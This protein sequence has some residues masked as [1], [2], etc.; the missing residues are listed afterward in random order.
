MRS[1]VYSLFASAL[2]C[3]ALLC[4]T[5]VAADDPNQFTGH[6]TLK[7]EQSEIHPGS[8]WVSEE[9]DVA[10]VGHLLEFTENQSFGAD[11]DV[12]R[13]QDTHLMFPKGDLSK[14]EVRTITGWNHGA[15][16]ERSSFPIGKH[17]QRALVRLELGDHNT[18]I[19]TT[20]VRQLESGGWIVVLYQ[21]EVFE[22]S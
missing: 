8:Q 4:S 6:W 11:E 7:A 12:I 5:A 9:M 22:R 18:L 17:K 16:V 13:R 20:T 19:R 1:V 10:L 14:G 15:L 2:V 21:R 3:A